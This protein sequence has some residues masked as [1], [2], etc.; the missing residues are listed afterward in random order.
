MSSWV[1][2][3]IE[4]GTSTREASRLVAVTTMRSAFTGESALG[5][6]CV[7]SALAMPAAP[8]AK[9]EGKASSTA[10]AMGCSFIVNLPGVIVGF[11][12]QARQSY[13]LAGRRGR[14]P[15]PASYDIPS[16]HGPTRS[17][18]RR[19]RHRRRRRRNDVRRHGGPAGPARPPDRPLRQGGR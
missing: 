4:N 1:C 6:G 7:S 14:L 10:L 12:H 15:M 9:V 5:G 13:Y 18:L 8:I 16:A 19:L 17:R 11:V 3:L 2:A